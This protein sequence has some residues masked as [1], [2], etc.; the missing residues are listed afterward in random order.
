MPLVEINLCERHLK[1]GR[2]VSEAY[3]PTAI[4]V[5]GRPLRLGYRVRRAPLFAQSTEQIVEYEPWIVRAPMHQSVP[6]GD[7]PG[8]ELGTR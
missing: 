3:H 6:G 7:R 4:T 2:V 5:G 1:E 8:I